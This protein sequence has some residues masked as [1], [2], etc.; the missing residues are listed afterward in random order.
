MFRQCF[1]VPYQKSV[2]SKHHCTALY[3]KFTSSNVKFCTPLHHYKQCRQTAHISE[4]GEP[5]ALIYIG[6]LHI[7]F[8]PKCQIQCHICFIVCNSVFTC[9]QFTFLLTQ[10]KNIS[11]IDDCIFLRGK[12]ISA[13]LNLIPK[14]H[15]KDTTTLK[16]L[17]AP[18]TDHADLVRNYSSFVDP[19]C[20]KLQSSISS[21]RL[22]YQS[23]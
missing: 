13:S 12:W 20:V 11:S 22:R 19:L 15:I 17:T 6:M 23:I 8:I 10:I 21:R 16:S 14:T 4:V 9:L 2:T 1:F 3:T 7:I 18:H 5:G